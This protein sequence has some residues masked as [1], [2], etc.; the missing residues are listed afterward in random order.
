M[1]LWAYKD[2]P[3]I[4]T[5][6]F[7][8]HFK[9]DPNPSVLSPNCSPLWGLPW[10]LISSQSKGYWPHL[11]RFKVPTYHNPYNYP[12][13]C[14]LFFHCFSLFSVCHWFVVV[15]HC[16]LLFFLDFHYFSLVVKCL[17]CVFYCV[18][19]VFIVIHLLFM[20]SE[21]LAFISQSF[22]SHWCVSSSGSEKK[23]KEEE[24]RVQNKAC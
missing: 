21:S 2:G 6:N 15:F 4:A 17:S 22:L 10:D 5:K 23:D 7:L 18:S 12:S 8:N 1:E 19:L 13:R 11:K 24:L 3:K 16:F 20:V 14:S 9:P